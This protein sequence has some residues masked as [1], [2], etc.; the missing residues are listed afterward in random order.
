MRGLADG[1]VCKEPSLQ[2]TPV[3]HGHTSSALW[4][5]LPGMK[6]CSAPLCGEGELTMSPGPRN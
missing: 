5:A 4:R 2:G 6:A 3:G 1:D